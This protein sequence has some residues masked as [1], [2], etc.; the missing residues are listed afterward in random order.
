[1]SL[2][3][4]IRIFIVNVYY[5]HWFCTLLDLLNEKKSIQFSTLNNKQGL[6]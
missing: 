1:M 2:V 6:L 3:Y 5:M 4:I